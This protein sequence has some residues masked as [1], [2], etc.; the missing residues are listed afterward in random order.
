[1]VHSQS[2]ILLTIRPKLFFM[3]A[4]SYMN[5]PQTDSSG[6]SDIG[7]KRSNNEDAFVAR[8]ELGFF[9]VADG[10]GGAA[11]GELASCIFADTALE[12]FSTPGGRTEGETMERVKRAFSLANERILDHVK[13]NALHR[14]MACT[15]ELLALSHPGF[16]LGHMGDSRTYRFRKNNLKQLTQDHSFIQDQ[17]D[18]GLITQEEARTHPNRNVIFRAVGAEESPALDLVRGKTCSG[19]LF[20][21]CSD[22]L[23]DMVDNTI[24]Q[25]VIS[26]ATT[27]PQ[28]A[29]KLI[30]LAKSS[31]G[32]DNIT[33][34][35]VEII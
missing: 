3:S 31:G 8:P 14:G 29:Q 11:A 19:D 28:K 4:N 34:V 24:I 15:A 22:G 18:Q 9:L 16:V 13:E 26:L 30:D 7:L 20:L 33:V 32:N 25:G 6:K 35:L 2:G 17:I 27:L 23:T 21:L 1:M 5:L 12:L 10:M